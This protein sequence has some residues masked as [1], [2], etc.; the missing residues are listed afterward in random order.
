ME[1]ELQELEEQLGKL[2][3]ADMPDNILLRMEQA[4]ENWQEQDVVEDNIVPFQATQPE[5]GGL[6][7]FNLWASAAA[8]ALVAAVSYMVMNGS[9][10]SGTSEIVDSSAPLVA[11]SPVASPINGIVPASN[12]QF[13]THIKSA[14]EDV[15]TYDNQGRP[16]RLMRVDFEDEVTVRDRAGRLYKV[17]QPRSEYYLIPIEVH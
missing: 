10:D 1:N 5:T 7:T 14:T 3:A 4:M 16:T 2:R 17:K 12:P 13:D 11:P 8:V 6:K 9:G 15:I